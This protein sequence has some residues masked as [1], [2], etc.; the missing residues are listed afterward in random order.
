M[1]P[2]RDSIFSEP[3]TSSDLKRSSFSVP[4]PTSRRATSIASSAALLNDDWRDSYV[5]LDA[6]VVETSPETNTIIQELPVQDFMTLTDEDIAEVKIKAPSE[7]PAR[8][9]PPPP[10]LPPN[11]RSPPFLPTRRISTM[12][13]PPLAPDEVAA[14]QAARIAKKYDFDF[15]YV[16]NFWPGQM[17]HL[18]RPGGG[19]RVQCHSH[20]HSSSTV[21]SATS[22]SSRPPSTLY[23]PTSDC[24]TTKNSTP[25]NS[26]QL[27][28][29]PLERGGDGN[30]DSGDG[31]YHMGECCPYPPPPGTI[32]TG[33]GPSRPG[34]ITGRLLT[35]YGLN[36]LEAPFRLSARAHRKIL[37]EGA[38]GW[39]EYRKSDARDNEFARGYARSF[40]TAGPSQAHMPPP[41]PPWRSS[42][43][44]STST[45]TST[46]SSSSKTTDSTSSSNSNG[47]SMGASEATAAAAT[48]TGRTDKAPGP[49]P[50][51]RPRPPAVD[52]GIVF[53]AYRRPR[54]HGGTVHSSKAELDALEREAET[55][56]ELLLDFHQ[57]RRRWE[58][59][60]E[61]VRSSG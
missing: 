17:G 41:L 45:C 14:F 47:G 11:P 20:S 27:Q 31:A 39:V 25:R 51:P 10:V 50:R 24:P 16:V 58:L 61:A 59:Y 53:A 19:P 56:V 55:L 34:A 57:G 5:P 4:A 40:Y 8:L 3:K 7:P 30:G 35:G 1:I 29:A 6:A 46:S 49:G 36:T 48:A 28:A 22:S 60:Q 21:S 32:T 52:R 15:L 38:D 37:R 44:T 33:N 12:L 43:Y 23:S 13:P 26:L 54:G 2:R 18:H 42:T 9:P